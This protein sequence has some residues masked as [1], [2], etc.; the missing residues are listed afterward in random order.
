MH[1]VLPTLEDENGKI[2]SIMMVTDM[3]SQNMIDA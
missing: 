2:P 3:G 1:P